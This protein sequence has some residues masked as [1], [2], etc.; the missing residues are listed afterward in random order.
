MTYERTFRHVAHAE[1]SAR[2]ATGWCV[3]ATLADCHHGH[4][5]VMMELVEGWESVGDA[6]VDLVEDGK[7]DG[8]AEFMS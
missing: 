7:P 2:E 6:A 4:H 8:N 3:V 5:G 1:I